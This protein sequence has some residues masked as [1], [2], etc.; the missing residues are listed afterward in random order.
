MSLLTRRHMKRM[1]IIMRGQIDS[2]WLFWASMGYL[3]IMVAAFLVMK[4]C[5]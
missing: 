5:A 2:D 4:G 1:I 3:G